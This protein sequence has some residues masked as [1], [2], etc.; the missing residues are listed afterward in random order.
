VQL[1]ADA[2]PNE[3]TNDAEPFFFNTGLHG[4]R[5]V[6]EAR[7]G[8]RR[9]NR[10]RQGVL[11]YLQQPGFGS[12]NTTNRQGNSGIPVETIVNN[13]EIDAQDIAITLWL[14][15]G[16]TVDNLLVGRGADR[17]G[18]AAITLERR[19]RLTLFAFGF[20]Q[21]VKLPGCHAP[22]PGRKGHC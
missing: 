7:A 12:I 8:L 2:M 20:S 16:K 17:I 1:P 5:Y 9:S 19:P 14:L 4:V 3:I 22:P 21:P 10:Q 15:I 6:R 18:K 11:R 13:P